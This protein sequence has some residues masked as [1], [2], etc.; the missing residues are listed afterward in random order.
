MKKLF[1]SLLI[2]L[3]IAGCAP[4]KDEPMPLATTMYKPIIV[5]RETLDKSIKLAHPREIINPGK[6]Y[7]KDNFIFISEKNS[8]IHIIDNTNPENPNPIG[9]LVA[10][11]TLDLAIKGSILYTDCGTDLVSIDLS[12]PTTAVVTKRI[13]DVFPERLPPDSE[14]IPDK[15]SRNKRPENTVIINWI[16]TEQK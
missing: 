4:R 2:F 1:V 14:T 5:D 10:P 15:Y 9:F 3:S 12:N 8:G 6:I 16:K 13:N 11:G 7:M